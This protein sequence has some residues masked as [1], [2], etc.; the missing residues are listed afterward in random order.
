MPWSDWIRTVEVEP[1][2]VRPAWALTHAIHAALAVV[3]N[4]V[5][6][7]VPVLAVLILLLVTVSMYGDLTARFY[8]VRRLMPRRSSQNVTSRGSRP[9]APARVV[10]T[11]HHDSA[12]SGMMF[13]RR[14]RPPPRPLRRLRNLAGPLDL[15]FWVAIASLLM[16]AGR[17]VG[18]FEQGEATWLTIAQFAA[19]AILLVAVAML[20]DVALS[21]PVPGANDNASGVAAALD[22]GRRLGSERLTNVDLWLVFPGAEEGLMLGMREWM[23]EHASEID[24][25]RTFFLN[26][27][28]VGAGRVRFVSGEGFVVIYQ[29]DARLVELGRSIAASSE[30]A[31]PDPYVWR[32]GT[33]GTIPTMR[34]FSGIT[35]CCTDEYGRVPHYHRQSDTADH[36]EPEAVA[37]AVDFAQALVEGIDQRVVP[38][39]LPSLAPS[40]SEALP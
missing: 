39:A 30:S 9:D 35:I 21:D 5:S 40:A 24:P 26:I 31:D 12:R 10:V 6:V 8:L 18:G 37:A 36:V 38:A 34:G 22:L 33:D 11:A 13:N 32:V 19:T 14:R 7:Y 1:I 25:R 2:G 3:A 27:D 4:V 23:R 17:L 15:V 16:A 29:H 20:V 28:S